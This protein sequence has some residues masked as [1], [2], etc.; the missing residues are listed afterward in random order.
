MAELKRILHE[1]VIALT[2]PFMRLMPDKVPVTF[3]GPDAS[4]DLCNSIAQS[5]SKK[6]LIV[7]D[8]GLVEI[9]KI[10]KAG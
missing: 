2:R 7:T 8:R 10:K 3:I 6:L 9:A 5:G 1:I 4:R